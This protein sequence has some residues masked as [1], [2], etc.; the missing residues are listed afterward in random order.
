MQYTDTI[1]PVV[2]EALHKARNNTDPPVFT[3]LKL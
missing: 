1:L 3:C 2:L